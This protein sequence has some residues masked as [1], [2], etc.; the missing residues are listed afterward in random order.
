VLC[1][2]TYLP[3]DGSGSRTVFQEQASSQ[4][5]KLHRIFGTYGES[6]RA[7]T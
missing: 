1:K 5:E 2:A 3:F 4:T 7:F 6:R